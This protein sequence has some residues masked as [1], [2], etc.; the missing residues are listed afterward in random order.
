MNSK[1]IIENLLLKADIKINGSRPWDITVHN[2]E[3][4]DHILRFGTLG[5]GETYMDG[6]WDCKQLDEMINK[7]MV[8]NIP[9]KLSGQEK[10]SL[11]LKKI[12]QI[13]NPQKI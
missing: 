11:V 9:E 7:A 6:L 1:D 12:Q 3:V 2:N 10:L 4:F 5:I 13:I 8:A